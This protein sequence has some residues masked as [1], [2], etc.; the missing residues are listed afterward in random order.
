MAEQT[1]LIFHPTRLAYLR[2]YLIAIFVIIVGIAVSFNLLPLPS[3]ISSYNIYFLFFFVL[4]GIILIGI[5]ELWRK[6]DKYAITNYRIIERHGIINI[7]EDAIYWD[8]VSNYSLSQNVL[9][10]ILK[11]GIIQ[12]WAV[13]GE[14]KPEVVIKRSPKIKRI[15]LLLDKLIQKR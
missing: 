7:K 15:R 8:K 1:Y 4:A 14:N 2:W 13:G 6:H 3:N 12:L 5:A 11:I 10:R 9:D